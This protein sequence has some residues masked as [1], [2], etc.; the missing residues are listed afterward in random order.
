[1]VSLF[2]I[3]GQSPALAQEAGGASE[4]APIIVTANKKEQDIQ[5]TNVTITALSSEELADKGMDDFADY[6]QFIP[7]FDF[8][9]Q[10]ASQSQYVL[11][12]ASVSRVVPA[13]PQNRSLVGIYFNDVPM[14]MNGLNPDIDLYD[15]RVEVLKGPQGSLFGDSAMAGAVRYIANSP[16][17]GK[18]EASFLA[19]VS[20]TKGGGESFNVKGMANVPIVADQMALR[21]VGVYRDNAGWSDNIFLGTKN[22]NTEQTEAFRAAL[23]GEIGPNF[24][25]E[26]TFLYQNTD[27]G[28]PPYDTDAPGTDGIGGKAQFSRLTDE[29]IKDKLRLGVLTLNYDAGFGQITSV[30]SYQK[31]NVDNVLVELVEAYNSFFGNSPNPVL[32]HDWNMD[33]FTQELRIATDLDGPF[34][35]TAGIYYSDQE[36]FFGNTVLY[37]GLDAAIA[38]GLNPFGLLSPATPRDSY[39]CV[40]EVDTAYCGPEIDKYKQFAVFGELYFNLTDELQLIAGGRYYHYKQKFFQDFGGLLNFGQFTG[41]Q[42][43][44]ES[45]FNPKFGVSYQANP[46][47]LLYANVAKGFRLGGISNVLPSFCDGDLTALGLTRSDVASY[48]P[49]SLWSYEGGVKSTHM[50]GRLTANG[51]VYYTEWNDIQTPINLACGYIPTTNAGKLRSYGFEG[52]LRFAATDNL[53]LVAS[54]AVNDS[55]LVGNAPA[56]GG[57]DGDRPPYAVKF[58]GVAGIDYKQ[59]V[60]DDMALGFNMTGKYQSKAYDSFTRDNV[61]FS[62]FVA[63]AQVSLEIEERYRFT[64]FADNFTDEYI[65]SQARTRFGVRSYYMGQPRTFGVQFQASY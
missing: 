49:D 37:P 28:T 19:N 62:Q 52:E 26:L 21:L 5:S 38:G 41:S 46:D 23:G 55:A 33:R 8:Q 29:T 6:A 11:R 14:D 32:L 48:G 42:K 40:G 65:A 1:M 30:T 58:K 43:T 50:G 36:L 9:K 51:A 18:V 59:P 61:L 60:S 13:E 12:G 3:G 27:A 24:S 20:T 39:G 54:F 16:D 2:V 47:L 44:K 35:T 31:R 7:G 10:G 63:N 57:L 17:A 4:F 34:N 22:T 53:N 64:I 25:Y 56:V 45:G 15:T